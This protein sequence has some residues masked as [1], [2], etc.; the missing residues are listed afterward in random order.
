MMKFPQRTKTHAS[1]SRSFQAFA[2]ALPDHWILRH[3]TE[4]DYGLDC[5]VELV[6]LS[7]ELQGEMVAIQLKS[8]DALQWSMTNQREQ[9]TL[10]GIKSS[11]VAYWLGLPMP[12]FLVVHERA[13]NSLYAVPA[14][15]QARQQYGLLG[16]QDSISFYLN[17]EDDLQSADG[18]TNL[19]VEALSELSYPAFAA[20]LLDLLFHA[21]QHAELLSG[22]INLDS[23]MAVEDDVLIGVVRLQGHVRAVTTYTNQDLMLRPMSHW[24]QLDRSRFKSDDGYELHNS[25]LDDIIGELAPGALTAIRAARTLVVATERA[26]WNSTDPLLVRFCESWHTDVAIQEFEQLMSYLQKMGAR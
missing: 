17:R 15:K 9:A 20:A 6:R 2:S 18:L 16:E 23:F 25:T 4:R 1:E 12:A 10:S 11:T 19:V 21:R 14:K 26:F 13:T 5:I 24:L 22:N 3:V 7:G 8:V